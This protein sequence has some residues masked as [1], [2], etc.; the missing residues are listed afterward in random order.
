MYWF[1]IIYGTIV[2][3]SYIRKSWSSSSLNNFNQAIE[4]ATW[5][6][7]KQYDNSVAGAYK[8]VDANGNI[9]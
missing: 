4:L 6:K 7:I 8:I 3:S 9:I 2:K 5:Q 1:S